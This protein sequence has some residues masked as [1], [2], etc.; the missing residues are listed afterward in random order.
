MLNCYASDANG[1]ADPN[2]ATGTK[3]RKQTVEPMFGIIKNAI[4]YNRFRLRGLLNA[5][6]EWSLVALAYNCRRINRMRVA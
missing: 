1:L 3:K 4:E 6:T 5:A 2:F